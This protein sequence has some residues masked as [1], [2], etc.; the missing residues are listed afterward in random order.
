MTAAQ[1]TSR[2][3]AA[4]GDLA[5]R[6]EAVVR[7]WRAVEVFTPGTV[8]VVDHGRGGVGE[9]GGEGMYRVADRDPLPWQR[10]HR[11]ARER[12]SPGM[13]W[14]H[15]VFGGVFSLDLLYARMGA[16]FGASDVDVDERV[17][18]GDTALFTVVLDA[19]GRP[20]PESL[21]L[22]TAAWGL[23]RALRPGPTDPRWLD[24]F[25][26][27]SAEIR[28]A[29]EALLAEREAG[30]EDEQ[31]AAAADVAVGDEH[32]TAAPADAAADGEGSPV[33]QPGLGAP[34]AG[35]RPV[36]VQELREMVGAAV[37]RLRLADL[38]ADWEIRVLSKRVPV[39]RGD[40]P[41]RVDDAFLNSF[42]LDDLD[43]V[44]RA[45]AEGDH[46][47][48]LAAFLTEDATLD[49]SARRDLR[50]PEPHPLVRA[51]L[52]PSR[53][54]AGRWPA[55]SSHPLAASQQ[56]A[57]VE[58]LAQL[59]DGA[60]LFAVNGPPG[61]G[62]TTLLRDLIAGVVVARAD[63]LAGL[64]R[65]GE[66]F[67]ETLTWTVDGRAHSVRALNPAVTGFEM[68]IASEN[69]GAVE[70]V[71]R[72][73]PAAT[74]ID[75]S[76][77]ERAGYFPDHA[78]R[79]LDEPAWGLISAALG[80]MANRH[81]F[82]KQFWFGDAGPGE[83]VTGFRDHL[84]ALGATR[85]DWAASVEAYRAAQATE[86][87]LRA[88]RAGLER[89]LAEHAELSAAVPLSR[90]RLEAARRTRDE[91]QEAAV[92]AADEA[93]TASER[94]ER[95][96]ARRAD[97]RTTKPGALETVFTWGKAARRWHTEDE[98]LAAAVSGAQARA[99]EAEDASDAAALR[100]KEAEEALAEAEQDAYEA[101]RL[102]DEATRTLRQAADTW[103][104]SFPDEQWWS[105]PV[106][107]ELSGPWL[108]EA[109]NAA[110]SE[111][112][113]AALDL[114]AA[115][116]AA[117]ASILARNLETT[118][119]VLQGRVP[120]DLA[121]PVARAAWQSLFLVV[122]VVS[123]TFASVPRLFT[124]LSR[125][126]LG[127]L[128]IDEAGQARPQSA[129]GAI[130]R[131][132]RI[133][134]VGDPMQLEPVVTVLNTTQQALRRHHH[135]SQT[136][137]PAS[138]CVQSLADRVTRLGTWLP[139]AD[140]EPVWVGAPLRVHRRCDEPMFSVVNGLV[141]DGMM[142]HAT[143]TREAPLTA[144]P[145]RW[146]DVAGPAAGGNW[147]PLEGDAVDRI[148]HYL[149]V[150]QGL[151]PEQIFVIS[152]F[153][154]VVA[155]LKARLRAH[156]GVAVSTVHRTQGQERDVVV[157][158]LGSDPARP[159]ARAWAAQ[160]PNLLNVAVSRA[161]QRLYVV[162]DRDLWSA[163]PHFSL[164][165]SSLPHREFTPRAP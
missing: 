138:T 154:Q 78:S 82:V 56:F 99:T 25:E 81:R 140:Q 7:Y 121:E 102:L 3:R 26:A 156:R 142:V 124:H 28:D 98:P 100:L 85:V 47:P 163:Q 1:G 69:N 54:P 111:V 91:A 162:G 20:D 30:A 108:D 110:R 19:E 4:L 29:I 50:R 117:T 18:R 79:L 161:R 93:E 84:T 43:R 37:A 24:G 132:R 34:T 112:F 165:A 61:T 123:T 60:G 17:P 16:V 33:A 38:S 118:R 42:H 21:V 39:R 131:A 76:W 157:L 9:R 5:R 97:H 67:A 126:A 8:R 44:A 80:N 63:R 72:Q 75:E 13:T 164:L 52:S 11:I 150:D 147:V 88:E 68:V 139:G 31:P 135:V 149:L 152:P 73:I 59:S 15:L 83:E 109:W 101:G 92:E 141:Y 64:A 116:V 45:V 14:Q 55:K 160:K 158:V 120:G 41:E 96:R 10:E 77:H 46:G 104:R 49:T 144:L 90:R 6:R 40:R 128:F 137:V 71:S 127:W 12:L 89:L 113:L 53:I 36:G 51:G 148:L 146:V 62:K 107:R 159:G 48:G 105:D 143:P 114:H 125:E 23:G 130:W 35:T 145:T 94:E 106:R 103:G 58:I 122:P 66:A 22:S 134:A 57:V 74:A 129:L 27:D 136:W 86:A 133:V 95:A 151:K 115:F 87:G 153:R 2:P 155:G 32:K 65:P 119:K 70:N